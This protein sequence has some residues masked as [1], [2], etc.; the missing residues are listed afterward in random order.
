MIDTSFTFKLTPGTTLVFSSLFFASP[1]CFL[2][3]SACCYPQLLYASTFYFPSAF[4]SFSCYCTTTTCLSASTL[5]TLL[6]Q[7]AF[8]LLSSLI[9]FLSPN[10]FFS[11][12]ILYLFLIHYYVLPLLLC[13]FLLLVADSIASCLTEFSRPERSPY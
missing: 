13:W 8:F 5:S 3:L 1:F 9:Y 11:N 12:L 2:F 10:L 6:L 4:F 7:S